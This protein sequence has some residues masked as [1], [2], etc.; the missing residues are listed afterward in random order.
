M[1]ALQHNSPASG[2]FLINEEPIILQDPKNP[3]QRGAYNFAGPKESTEF[4]T[5]IWES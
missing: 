5:H 3:N 1:R 2:L 4:G